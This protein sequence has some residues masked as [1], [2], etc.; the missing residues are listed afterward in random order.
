LHLK[1]DGGKDMELAPSQLIKLYMPT[2]V[3]I[4]NIYY[5]PTPEAR[6]L[7][8]LNGLTDRGPIKRGRFL[9]LTD[10]TIQH[11]DGKKEKLKVSYINKATVQ[12]AVTLG[13]ANSGRGIGALDGPKS[14]PFVEKTP[15][16]VHIETHDY[17]ISGN[18]YRINY[19][20]VWNVLEDMQTF[21]PLT[22]CEVYTVANGTREMFPFIAVNKEHI[23]S[24]QE[25]NGKQ[26][27]G[28]ANKRGIQK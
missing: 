24:L 15:T 11:I 10:V 20:K 14:Y 26:K 16:P 8:A 28:V 6:L 25:E 13:D 27:T 19:Q 17:L 4:G 23:L 21:L 5:A 22:H 12:L 2:Q 9:E 1:L 3:L 7:D 18:M